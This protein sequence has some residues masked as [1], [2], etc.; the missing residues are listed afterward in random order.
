MATMQEDI[1][2]LAIH[3]EAAALGEPPPAQLDL[4]PEA[5]D[6]YT[7]AIIQA[8]K[9][10]LEASTKRAH[11]HPSGHRWWNDDCQEAVLALQG[12]AQDPDSPLTEIE[13]AQRTFRCTVCQAK[14]HYWCTQ[15][16]NFSD[17]KGIV[18]AIKWSRTEGSF[19]TPP[20]KDGNRTHTTANAKA[21]L[22]VKT[23]LQKAACA[24]DI[25]IN[26]SNPEATLPFPN[27]TTGEVYQA[28]FRAK[29]ST[30]G[31][32]EISND[33]LKKAWPVI[34]PHI[35]AL[36]K[37]CITTEWHPTL[38]RQAILVALPK[39]G[40]KDYSS[41][42]SY[43][44][45]SLL[46]TLGKGLER[47]MARRLA[48]IAIRHKVLHP[49]QFGALPC[50]SA[51]DL[52]AAL[53]HDIEE[54]WAR[55]LFASMLTLD[56]K[57]AFH[58]VLQ[59]R[60]TQRLCSQGWPPTV[61]RW[62]SSFTQ[63]RTAAIRLDEHQSPTFTVPAGLPQGSPVSPILFMLYVEPIFKIG[64]SLEENTV[65]LQNIATD[66]MEWGQR[67]GL[68]FDL[69]KTEL[70]HFARGWKKNNPT[71]S[72]QTPEG[73]VIIN[74]PQFNEATRWLGIWFD[75]KLKIKNT[76][77]NAG[78]EGQTGSQWHPSPCQHSMRAKAPL[79]RQ[80]TIACVVPVLCYGAV[81]HRE[82]A[83]PPMELLLDQRR[84]SLAIRVHQLDT[85]HPLHLLVI[86]QP[87]RY[88]STRLLR[89]VDPKNFHLIEQVDP[90]LL[91]PWDSN[92]EPKEQSATMKIQARDAF[93]R[94]LACIPPLSTVV[95][96]DG[97]KGKDSKTTGAG[98]VGYW[99]M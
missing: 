48:W 43:R 61:L 1:F 86:H 85:Q 69:A 99:G 81:L 67:E 19:P 82:S 60:L 8:I 96:T 30:P 92:P 3:K 2:H 33:V 94:W 32:D 17:S 55:G 71:C 5:L 35:S 44:L 91:S 38:F 74:H 7:S 50:R 4:T 90:L 24:E 42:R 51:T 56:I 45:I 21:E 14:R 63:D 87:S 27:I 46:S 89:A 66:L 64:K 76:H 31:Q 59:G 78:C 53:V 28:I 22:L 12:A 41:P 57:G 97:S 34:G 13:A 9:N 80:A 39:P 88:I 23:L 16:D 72:I 49:Q 11:A 20:L 6:Q 93:Q 95:Y 98:W 79:L 52:A 40:K 75:R 84:R 54:A 83:I 15:L 25:P 70:Q 29:S 73:I 36:Y 26:C 62:V 47:L 58:A 37:H 18:K 68:T 77:P 10:A 65:R